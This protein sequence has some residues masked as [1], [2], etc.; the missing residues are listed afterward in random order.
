[1]NNDRI[2]FKRFNDAGYVGGCIIL[3]KESL[4]SI[5]NGTDPIP[6]FLYQDNIELGEFQMPDRGHTSV[7]VKCDQAECL[8]NNLMRRNKL[9]DYTRFDR[10]RN[11]VVFDLH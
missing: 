5:T 10:D 8:Y 7:R 9:V 3:N 1:M 4:E 11:M 2:D 6:G